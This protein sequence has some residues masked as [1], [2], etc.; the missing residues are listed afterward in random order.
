MLPNLHDL[1][2]G[3][4]HCRQH[5]TGHLTD[6]DWLDNPDDAALFLTLT[7]GRRGLGVFKL[8]LAAAATRHHWDRETIT[9]I[10]RAAIAVDDLV[11]ASTGAKKYRPDVEQ[12][13]TDVMLEAG[14]PPRRLPVLPDA[15]QFA[16][17]SS[18][19]TV[20][21]GIS[22]LSGITVGRGDGGEPFKVPF[23]NVVIAADRGAGKTVLL[24]NIIAGVAEAADATVWVGDTD[25]MLLAPWLQTDLT[26]RLIGWPGVGVAAT[27]SMLDA[28]IELIKKRKASG[29][30]VMMRLGVDMYPVTAIDP[31]VLIVMEDG[32]NQHP[33]IAQKVTAIRRI[34]PAMRVQ[35][36]TATSGCDPDDIPAQDRKLADMS[37]AGKFT[38]EQYAWFLETTRRLERS[39]LPDRPGRF[40]TRR[41][42][43]PRGQLETFQAA[44]IGDGEILRLAQDLS[45][46]GHTPPLLRGSDRSSIPGFLERWE[47]PEVVAAIRAVDGF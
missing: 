26:R 31:A 19:S 38:D 35:V 32:Y 6:V 29:A 21:D 1:A 34:G 22:V 8:Q 45:A 11:D 30:Q 2:V 18:G 43:A 44:L 23:G 17:V 39:Y 28:A 42:G 5:L 12:L 36:V 10:A 16:G 20:S 46:I 37:I 4:D 41:R 27:T 33:G 7:G 13:V 24:N 15:V 9:R 25:Q 14:R 40:V 47:R 3:L